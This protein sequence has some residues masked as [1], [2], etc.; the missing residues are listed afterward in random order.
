MSSKHLGAHNPHHSIFLGSEALG[1]SASQPDVCY[2]FITVCSFDSHVDL[3]IWELGYE[4][5]PS[6]TELGSPLSPL[7]YGDTEKDYEQR[8]RSASDTECNG[9]RILTFPV[10]RTVEK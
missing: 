1:S 4:V 6:H 10:L 2:I 9:P 5:Q 8:D 7:P 3:L